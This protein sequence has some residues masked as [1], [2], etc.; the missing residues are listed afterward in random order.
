[1]SDDKGFLKTISAAAS[2]TT[3]LVPFLYIFG[4]AYD[5]GYLR[6]YGISNQ[7]FVRSIQEYLVL[8]FYALLAIAITLVD[9]A[10]KHQIL[11]FAIGG[12]VF[13]IGLVI[14]FASRHQIEDRLKALAISSKQHRLFD[15]MF[16]PLM[17]AL[18]AALAPYVLIMSIAA[19]LLIPGMAYFK[20][21]SV[22]KDEIQKAT[23][24]S[25]GPDIDGDCVHLMENNRPV[26]SGIFVA[27]SSTHLA[28]FNYGKTSIFPVKEQVVEVV[29]KSKAPNSVAEGD[30]AR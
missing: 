10:A 20:G 28:L 5:Q 18:L 14:V 29:P 6:G 22:A 2:L 25:Y 17:S 13:I 12:L 1:M 19:V 27:R 15:Y 26:A 23:N 11:F 7:F 3:L 30:A 21:Q 16:I 4:Y 24:C 8:S 9:F